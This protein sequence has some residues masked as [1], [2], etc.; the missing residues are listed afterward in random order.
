LVFL[1]IEVNPALELSIQQ[2]ED[3]HLPVHKWWV[4]FNMGWMPTGRKNAAKHTQ[5]AGYGW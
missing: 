3:I 1:K 4:E 2:K 5:I